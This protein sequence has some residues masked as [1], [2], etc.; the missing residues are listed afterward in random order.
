MSFEVPAWL[1]LI[2]VFV[3][4]GYLRRDLRLHLPMRALGLLLLLLLL[5]NPQIR[6]G[7]K[8]LDL[9][10]LLDR[11]ESM[12]GL[13]E[14]NAGEWLDILRKSKPSSKD[15][16]RVLNF[17]N[18]V[19]I[20]GEGEAGVYTG[21]RE[22]TRTALAVQTGL[23]VTREDRASRFLLFTDGYATEP[24]VDL[25]E[26]L[27]ERGIALDYR[28]VRDGGLDD[29]RMARFVVPG[30]VLAGEPFVVSV[31]CRGDVDGELP[32]ELIRDGEVLLRTSVELK[33]GVG[34]LDLSDR[35]VRAGAYRYEA[36]IS[37]NKDAYLGNNVLE[38]WVE[39]VG[40]PR[41]LLLSGYVNDPLAEVLR[42]QGFTV[43]LVTET[44]S[45]PVGRLAGAKACIFNNVPAHQVPREFQKALEFFVK[46]QAGGL[47]M[48]GGKSSFGSGGYYRSPLDAL[49]PVTMELKN[50]HRKVTT[51]LA[52]VM[53]RSGSMSMMVGGVTKM[54]LANNGAV[55]AVNL[56]GDRDYVT[57]SAVDTSNHR[58][59]DLTRVGDGRRQ[60]VKKVRSIR[61]E[62]GGIYVFNGLD[63]AWKELKKA[64]SKMKHVILFA[65]ASDSEQPG[66]YKKLL[67]EMSG[68]GATVS[69]IG[70]GTENDPDAGFLADVAKRGG[71]RV[72]FTQNAVE[73]PKIFSQETVSVARSAFL[74][75]AVGVRA[76]GDWIEVSP[77]EPD[78]LGGVEAYNL[79]YLRPE[80]S[81]SLLST[82]EYVAPLV[83]QMR[84]GA[85]RTMAV[86]FPMGGEF[87]ERVREW[88][89]YGDF[90]QTLTRWLMGGE[91]PS[92]LALRHRIDG[93]RLTLD[94]LYD[95]EE[96]EKRLIEAPPRV[97]LT[98][99]G[100]EGYEVGADFPWPLPVDP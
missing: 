65:D 45:L 94:L 60:I 21:G 12:E 10:V 14:E 6:R 95:E 16:I 59:V 20:E 55:N 43:D 54:D 50:E 68:L 25:P 11:S 15:E 52:V 3:C 87:S 47:L 4:V 75:E 79:S 97:R 91:I 29:S 64:P 73:V 74:R 67:E 22:L 33:G 61:S 2:P 71:G 93:T 56:L 88:Q 99:G 77:Q 1:L 5:A 72:F 18:E 69:V 48:V 90:V 76:T 37:P 98:D 9:W 96:W 86:S 85:G 58:F 83:A 78:W 80:A 13:V 27:K 35:M 44:K 23:A 34:R 46:D 30:R 31:V 39:V 40:G 57:V 7:E 38:Q 63:G 51:A 17:G 32:L 41:V 49:L 62:G 28:V 70:L 36:R 42:Q 84:V 66:D 100:G 53:D 19:L 92:G 8:A 89:G 82:D 24:L 81:A 26:K